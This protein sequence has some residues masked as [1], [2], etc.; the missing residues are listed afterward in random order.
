QKFKPDIV[1]ADVLLQ[2]KSGYEVS[3][4][5]K[6][7]TDFN[8]I[9][10]VLM[11][12]GFMELDKD[13]F[14]ASQANSHLEKPF[15]VK[16]L[17]KL[18][19][20]LVP[21]TKSQKLSEFLSFPK[22]PEFIEPPKNTAAPISK[23]SV[24]QESVSISSASRPHAEGDW[25]ME[26]FEPP[27]TLDTEI[28]EGDTGFQEVALHLKSPAP[29][30]EDHDK[31]LLSDNDEEPAEDQPWQRKDLSKF[32]IKENIDELQS[33]NIDDL[34][35]AEPPDLPPAQASKKGQPAANLIEDT[36]DSIPVP[37]KQ[38]RPP[39]SSPV[40]TIE[41]DL[42]EN[43]ELELEEVELKSPIQS[44]APAANQKLS[45]A[46]LEALIRSQSK[47]II[48]SVVWKVVPD[49]AAQIIEREL[50]RLLDERDRSQM[51]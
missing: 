34:L 27:P 47:E 46:Q 25:N 43:E 7:S 33:E 12:S 11:W 9:P 5:L 15:D 49:L 14:Q 22:M 6:S 35:D 24:R 21:R 38:P 26:D 41:L 37:H 18:I 20:E 16:A 19:N 3:A 23:E 8:S 50:K 10:V 29:A 42:S 31:N 51:F 30:V 39:A 48:E 32:M 4:E 40:R 36:K 1:F 28:S 2:R 44:V 45:E 17:R 13:K